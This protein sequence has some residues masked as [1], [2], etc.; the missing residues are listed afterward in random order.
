MKRL[1]LPVLIAKK[2]VKKVQNFTYVLILDIKIFCLNMFVEK[3]VNFSTVLK[4]M[5]ES[6][7]SFVAA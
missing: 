6:Q 1:L 5:V 7:T 2:G 3:E 4:H